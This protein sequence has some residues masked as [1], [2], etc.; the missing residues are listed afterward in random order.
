MERYDRMGSF[1]WLGL[2]AAICIGSIQIRL[3]SFHRPGPGFMP[4]LSG[5]SMMLFGVILMVSTLRRADNE[6][7]ETK[8]TKLWTKQNWM[9]FC[10]TLLALFGYALLM[11]FLGFY[12]TTFLFLFFLFKLTEPKKWLMPLVLAGASAVLSYLIFSVWLMSQFPGG[13][14]G[15]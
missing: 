15:F 1:F 11:D 8:D 9:G 13:L 4:F 7:G 10:L 2:G 5:A 12:T 3:G 14:F 6:K